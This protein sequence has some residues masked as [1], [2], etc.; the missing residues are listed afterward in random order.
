MKKTQK[1]YKVSYTL[2]L[3]AL[4][5]C[6]GIAT[7]ITSCKKE[8]QLN[9]TGVSAEQQSD[10]ERCSGKCRVTYAEDYGDFSPGTQTGL[11]FHYNTGG[12]PDSGF[13]DTLHVLNMFY[14]N[15]GKL[16]QV[17]ILYPFLPQYNTTINYFYQ[18]NSPLPTYATR[19]RSGVL[20]STDSFYYDSRKNLIHYVNL[21]ASGSKVIY[22]LQ[23][24][25]QNNVTQSLFSYYDATG[26]LTTSYIEN[27]FTSFDN[28]ANY[29]NNKWLRYALMHTG[30]RYYD[31]FRTFCKNNP[32]DYTLNDGF[33]I[34]PIHINYT[35]NSSGFVN[36]ADMQFYDASTSTYSPFSV[37]A[38][39][40]TCDAGSPFRIISGSNPSKMIFKN[41]VK[42]K[43][44]EAP[45]LQNSTLINKTR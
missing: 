22:Y 30:F 20:L 29:I 23:Y 6:I 32:V 19:E 5:V 42:A 16:T 43:L 4:L 7:L 11:S 44:L 27:T 12:N 40:S 41:S 2:K 21:N 24:N 14:S 1:M 33:S 25:N 18:N 31:Y 13:L 3:Q 9:Q 28:K 10:A 35:Y 37:E 34:Y 8:E 36:N 26:A 39:L 45:I 15:S 38:S 17:G